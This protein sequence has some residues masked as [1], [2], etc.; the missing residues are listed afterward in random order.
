MNVRLLQMRSGDGWLETLLR[1]AGS[2]A[3]LAL[4]EG[5]APQLV[6]CPQQS[7]SGVA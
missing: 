5:D 4:I 1:C 2:V 6:A 7:D 3:T